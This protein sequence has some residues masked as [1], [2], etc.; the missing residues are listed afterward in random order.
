MKKT[1]LITIRTTPE[2]ARTL[3][4]LTNL[5]SRTLADEARFVIEIGAKERLK[6]IAMDSYRRGLVTLEKASEIAEV[7]VWEMT[8]I[9]GTEKIP[10]NLDLTAVKIEKK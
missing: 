4:K 2:V 8:E 3:K 6:E 10:Y 1:E 5:E 9:L 7:G